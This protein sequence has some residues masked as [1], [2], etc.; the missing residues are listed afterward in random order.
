M[1]VDRRRKY[2]TTIS[3][4]PGITTERLFRRLQQNKGW[5]NGIQHV[6]LMVGGND[7][8]AGL[9][10]GTVVYWVG[11]IATLVHCPVHVVSVP[12]MV[13]EALAPYDSLN[14]ALKDWAGDN[15]FPL[16][17]KLVQGKGQLREIQ[18]DF[19]EDYDPI[20]LS[21]RGMDLFKKCLHGYLGKRL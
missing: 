5:L 12:P 16:G 13:G 17:E 21:P 15:Y 9:P 19:F 1:Y 7:L 11:Q 20:H 6:V 4:N 2:T 8:R 10:F 18:S 3:A 14:T